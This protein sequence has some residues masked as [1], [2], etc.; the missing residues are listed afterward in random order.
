[1]P[2]AAE[3]LPEAAEDLPEAAEDLPEAAEDLP[4]ATEDL[5]E[6]AEDED[7]TL[8]EA[9]EEV[10]VEDSELPPIEAFSCFGEIFPFI[11][12]R[13]RLCS[14]VFYDMMCMVLY[15]MI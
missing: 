14:I 4:E 12:I 1:L 5:P 10:D 15:D 7:D 11:E 2:E 3:D 8:V 9:E 13:Y 6:A